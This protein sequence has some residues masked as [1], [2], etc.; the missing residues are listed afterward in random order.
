MPVEKDYFSIPATNELNTYITN[1]EL[2]GGFN[3]AKGNS[4]AHFSIPAQERLLP[5]QDMFLTGQIIICDSNG[6]PLSTRTGIGLQNGAQLGQL[7]NLNISNW[8]GLQNVIDKVM[9][10]SKKSP[11][12][13]MN[14]NNYGM[15]QNVK[16][17]LVANEKDYLITPLTRELACGDK[18]VI[19]RH[20][21][22]QMDS[23]A[24]AS[25]VMTN[26]NNFLDENFGQYFSMR[27]DTSL[28]NL[29]R[30][31]HLGDGHLGGLLLTLHFKDD[32]GL[33]YRNWEE[34]DFTAGGQ[35]NADISGV[36]YR[37][38][39]LRLEGY[40]LVPT[41]E[42]D[43]AY[44]S[45]IMMNDRVNLIDTIV[46]S[47]NIT[48]YTPQLKSVKSFVNLFLDDNQQNNL[49]RNESNFRNP[50]GLEEYTQNKNNIRSASGQDFVIKV[51]PSLGD[52]Q[53]EQNTQYNPKDLKYPVAGV[54]DS[55]VRALFQR[56]LLDGRLSDRS[57]ATLELANESITA[58]Y[59]SRANT[60][61]AITD[62]CID[63]RK[64]NLCGIGLDYGN[65]VGNVSN[66]VNQDYSLRLKS[67]V[68]SGDANQP[69]QRRDRFEIQETFVR[70]MS[71]LDTTNLVK[72]M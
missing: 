72:T 27:I 66:F 21:L 67:Q 61:A 4:I 28:T 52:P 40:Y 29:R 60:G 31:L 34:Q 16:S 22:I 53:S 70:N 56:A 45:Q 65:G 62:G 18:A 1:T 50:L 69:A 15:Y 32:N 8:G 13:I 26:V 58:E 48:N 44:Q 37:I 68:A 24:S 20:N 36:F 39:N 41:P 42:E 23:T 38:K 49:A 57:S 59:S 11:V 6:T 47:N 9:I 30:D 12:E 14:V 51:L 25:G 19:N 3:F 55:E 54:G 2:N 33:F 5:V 71:S 46:S 35:P 43:R 7:G 17:G 63:N 64:A 10:Q